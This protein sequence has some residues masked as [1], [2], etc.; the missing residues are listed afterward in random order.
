[1]TVREDY[2]HPRT[3]AAHAEVDATQGRVAWWPAAV[4][5]VVAAGFYAVHLNLPGFFDNEGRYAE[6]ART[7]VTSGDWITPRLDGTLS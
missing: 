3:Q 4:L 5:A 7:M 1:M 6:V 2:A